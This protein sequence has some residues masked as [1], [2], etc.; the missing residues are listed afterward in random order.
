MNA[1]LP[2]VAPKEEQKHTF[3]G[4]LCALISLAS[5]E[6]I[7]VNHYFAILAVAGL[8]GAWWELRKVPSMNT[9]PEKVE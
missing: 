1:E 3:R 9:P 6:G 2:S 7:Y 8:A 5:T 4:Q